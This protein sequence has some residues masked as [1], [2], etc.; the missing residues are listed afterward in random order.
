MTA[1]QYG[2][3]PLDPGL[4]IRSNL[5]KWFDGKPRLTFKASSVRSAKAWQR[6]ARAKFMECLGPPPKRVPLR[7][8]VL[9]RQQMDGYHRT[10][11]TLTTA[12]HLKALCWLC[13]PDSVTA[14]TPRPAMIATPGHGI[15]AKDLLAMDMKGHLRPEGH[16]YQKDYALQVVRLDY[17]VLVVEPLGFGE[18]RD[19]E[20][21]HEPT[22]RSGCHAAATLA[23]FFGTTLAS[24]RIHDLRRSLD[25]LCTVPQIN[26]DRIGL[27]G[28]SGGG[29]LSLWAA[30]I[31]PRF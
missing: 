1:M 12:P 30:A 31:D 24:I 28:I 26:P 8:H 3:R 7:R 13:I 5:T 4:E 6:R 10:T 15:G 25:F 11:F 17:P 29:Q 16:G 2:T 9:E 27:M 23:I 19:R 20:L 22:A 18:R 14:H 21:L